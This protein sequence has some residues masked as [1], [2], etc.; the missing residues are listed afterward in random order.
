MKK[1]SIKKFRSHGDGNFKLSD[2]R[3]FGHNVIIEN[4][5]KI[6]HPG[7]ISIGNNVYIG[8]NVFLKGYYKNRIDIGNNTWIG[9]SAFLHGAGGIKIGD[10]VGI[11]PY[12][13]IL[14]SFHKDLGIDSL[15]LFNPLEFKKVIVGDGSDIGIG[16]IILAGV[17]IGRGVIIGAGAVVTK[18]IPDYAV[19]VGIPAKII[20][21]RC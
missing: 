20:R 10:F 13:K 21:H 8:H 2:F 18:D 6:F 3:K 19:A 5:V 9:Q 12:V 16:A 7:N 14:T 1:K 15:L 4:G 17:K 11:G